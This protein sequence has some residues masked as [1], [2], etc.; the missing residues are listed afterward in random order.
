METAQKS[1]QAEELSR[2]RREL[3]LVYIF[4]FL[5]L[6]LVQKQHF[7]L[8]ETAINSSK[9]ADREKEKEEDPPHPTLCLSLSLAVC[10]DHMGCEKLGPISPCQAILMAE[11]E[12]NKPHTYVVKLTPAT[13]AL[14]RQGRGGKPQNN[15]LN[16]TRSWKGTELGM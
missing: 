1:S 16:F 12:G 10:C 11:E 14:E 13:K 5:A 6:Y 3:L 9:H 15:A 7:Q 2:N 4:L 8:P